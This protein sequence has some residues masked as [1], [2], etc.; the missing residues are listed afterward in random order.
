[1]DLNGDSLLDLVILNY[2]VFGPGEQHFASLCQASVP[3]ARRSGMLASEARFGKMPAAA[4]LNR[5]RIR[6]A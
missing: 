5:Y 3:P 6:R 4:R 1:M 2:V